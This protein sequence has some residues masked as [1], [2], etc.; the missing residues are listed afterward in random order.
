VSCL[1]WKDG[2]VYVGGSFR[3]V[4]GQPQRALA[5][6]TD[7]GEGESRWIHSWRPK[8]D[9]RVATLLT[10]PGG[11]LAVGGDFEALGGQERF[12]FG[13]VEDATGR[14]DPLA[15]RCD[16]DKRV[17]S[18]VADTSDGGGRLIVGGFF[19]NAGGLSRS[20]LARIDKDSGAVLPQEALVQGTRGREILRLLVHRNVLYAVGVEINAVNGLERRNAFALDPGSFSLKPWRADL[21]AG[22][23]ALAARGDRVF[24]GGDFRMVNDSPRR[25]AA[26]D[27]Q[28]GEVLDWDP[29][30][31]NNTYAAEAQGG[32]LVVSGYW[33]RIAGVEAGGLALFREGGQEDETPAV[34]LLLS[35]FAPFH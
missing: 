1:A 8:C 5:A 25:L 15:T 30:P 3:E 6:F 29:H 12:N 35:F 11:S 17:T 33:K 10:L 24:I 31:D 22:A 18:I 9:G 20:L 19:S 7:A 4:E 32:M 2:I 34:P 14:G 26:V 13:V 23:G 21:D 27:A 16:F 28:S